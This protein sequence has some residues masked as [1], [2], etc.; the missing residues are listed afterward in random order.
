MTDLT[1]EQ[2]RAALKAQLLAR[3]TLVGYARYIDIP[4]VPESGEVDDRQY[5]VVE[6]PL[7]LHHAVML[8]AMQL[9]AQGLLLYDR[10]TLES[11]VRWGLLRGDRPAPAGAVAQAAGANPPP[12]SCRRGGSNFTFAAPSPDFKKSG[13][14]PSTPLL[15]SSEEKQALTSADG[16]KSAGNPEDIPEF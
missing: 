1:R 15:S 11:P 12:G 4:G 9:M 7:G 16:G 8:N 5:R 3:T 13:V 10:G 2:A 14:L 6:T